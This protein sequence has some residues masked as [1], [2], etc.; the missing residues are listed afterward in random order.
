MDAL[1]QHI[2]NYADSFYLEAADDDPEFEAW[3]S[4]YQN[5]DDPDFE[6]P[7]IKHINSIPEEE[8]PF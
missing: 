7:S 4:S 3:L 2:L 5:T 8:L 6:T 1:N